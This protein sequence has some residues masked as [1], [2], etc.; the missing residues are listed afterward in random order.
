MSWID[1]SLIANDKFVPLIVQFISASDT[2]DSDL[3]E[4]AVDCLCSLLSKKIENV[5]SKLQLVQA[6]DK[7]LRNQSVYQIMAEVPYM[8]RIEH[9][10]ISVI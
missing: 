4:A 7:F 2:S 10:T 6:V 1:I 8:T 9:T 3:A 5:V